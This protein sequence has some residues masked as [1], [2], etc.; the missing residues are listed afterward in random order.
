MNTNKNM[1]NDPQIKN[2]RKQI[3]TTK[4]HTQTKV[5]EDTQ[6]HRPT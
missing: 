1:K 5:S 4:K 6:K 2:K 3:M